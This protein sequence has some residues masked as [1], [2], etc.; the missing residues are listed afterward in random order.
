MR[1]ATSRL[2]AVIAV[3]GSASCAPDDGIVML[4]HGNLDSTSNLSR[5]QAVVRDADGGIHAKAW[6]G[7]GSS[8]GLVA[9]LP[10][11]FAVLLERHQ[12]A[13]AWVSI[14][15]FS[16]GADEG[17]VPLLSYQ[18]RAPIVEGAMHV[19]EVP[20]GQA[21]VAR[22][23]PDDQTCYPRA[24]DTIAAGS[25]GP[26]P[27]HLSLPRYRGELTANLYAETFV[28]LEKAPAVRD[29]D[30]GSCIVVANQR[31]QFAVNQLVGTKLVLERRRRLVA[32]GMFLDVEPLSD[33]EVVTASATAVKFALYAQFG[34]GTPSQLIA[35]TLPV[36]TQNASPPGA[37]VLKATQG[38]LRAP[39]VLE[40]NEY[41][42]FFVAPGRLLVRGRGEQNEWFVGP[43][44]GAVFEE[45]FPAFPTDVVTRVEPSDTTFSPFTA[46]IYAVTEDPSLKPGE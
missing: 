35:E 30:Q 46:A 18:V 17:S 16:G 32:L 1:R 31:R 23:C 25:C 42:V 10:A 12:S 38:A 34:S 21:C 22:T 26:I 19:L 8:D 45:P 44:G 40:P 39:L 2:A 14:Q 33:F 20:L 43:P 27:L 9:R 7:V 4:I 15:G 29:C 13:H 24:S 28:P 37:T 36:E 3:L 41:W 6:F 5:V 11:P